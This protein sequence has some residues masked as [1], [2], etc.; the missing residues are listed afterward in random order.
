MIRTIISI[1][2]ITVSTAVLADD[3]VLPKQSEESNATYHQNATGFY[4]TLGLGF[5]SPQPTSGHEPT[6]YGYSIYGDVDKDI[7]F[8]GEIGGGYD[9]GA[10]RIELTYGYTNN[11]LDTSQASA[12][13]VTEQAQLTGSITTQT[14]LIST[15]YD[16]NTNSPYLPYVG[17]GIG[18]GNVAQSQVTFTLPYGTGVSEAA[19]HGVFAY[20]AKLG[21]TYMASKKMDIFAEGVYLG[22]TAYSGSGGFA[23]GVCDMG[24]SNNFGAK[25]GT[26]YHFV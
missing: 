26:R 2:L 17:G 25:I 10:A 23:P 13:G 3:Q 1:L 21:I 8:S 15:Y 20:Q 24:A 11:A 19:N 4:T 18:Y 5:S 9:F 7:G 14:I 12:N 16:F 6:H 22:N